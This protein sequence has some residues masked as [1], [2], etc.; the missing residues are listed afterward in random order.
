MNKPFEGVETFVHAA[1]KTAFVIAGMHR[2]GTS[3]LTRVVSMLGAKLPRTLMPPMPD[4]PKGY[5]ESPAIAQLND[6]LL[7]ELGS[8]WDDVLG[9]LIRRDA[10]AAQSQVI[11]RIGQV[12]FTEFA[13]AS[14]LVRATATLTSS[15]VV[16]A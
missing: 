8:S 13:S 7:G 5:W 9:V 15:G 16:G 10:L 6:A 11:D 12:I 2:S 3:A 14:S 1:N 4:N